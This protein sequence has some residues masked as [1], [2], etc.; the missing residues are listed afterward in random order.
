MRP[1]LVE[2]LDGFMPHGIAST[3]APSWFTCI[4]LAGLVTLFAMLAVA[5]RIGIDRGVV[6]SMVLWCDV[7]AVIAGLTG[8]KQFVLKE[9]ETIGSK[10]VYIDGEVP[11]SKENS[12]DFRDVQL[13]LEEVKAIRDRCPSIATITPT[14]RCN[15]EVRHGERVAPNVRAVGIWPS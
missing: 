4:G 11:P 14:W 13:N 5:R 10:Y 8:M 2:W 15:V 1:H 12:M 7:T 9:F 6:A 3:I